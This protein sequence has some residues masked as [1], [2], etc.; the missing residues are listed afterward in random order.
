MAQGENAGRTLRHV[1]VV[2]VIEEMGAPDG[3]VLTLKLPRNSQP[4]TISPA[5]R[6]VVF[7]ADQRSGRVV[8]VAE[9]SFTPSSA[10]GDAP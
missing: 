10:A 7:L 6:L 1:A 2:R 9:K 8:A 3:R 5:M 4:A